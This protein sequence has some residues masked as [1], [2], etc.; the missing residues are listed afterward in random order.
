[1]EHFPVTQHHPVSRQPCEGCLFKGKRIEPRVF[2]FIKT[3][4]VFMEEQEVTE[5]R[6]RPKS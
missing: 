6:R 5:P 1:M 4:A 3:S 2:V